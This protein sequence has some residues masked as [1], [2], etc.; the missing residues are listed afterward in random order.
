MVTEHIFLRSHLFL[1]YAHSFPPPEQ[2]ANGRIIVLMCFACSVTKGSQTLKVGQIKDS[3]Y[4]YVCKWRFHLCSPSTNSSYIVY[5][6]TRKENK[7]G[8]CANAFMSCMYGNWGD[9]DITALCQD[10]QALQT[11][12]VAYFYA[13]IVYLLAHAV[14]LFWFFPRQRLL[15]NLVEH[16]LFP[17]KIRILQDWRKRRQRSFV[18][19][20]LYGQALIMVSIATGV[21]F[22]DVWSK[23]PHTYYGGDIVNIFTSIVLFVSTIFNGGWD[24]YRIVHWNRGAEAS[25]KLIKG[26]FKTLHERDEWREGNDRERI[27]LYWYCVYN[28]HDP[29]HPGI[30]RPELMR[31]AL[32]YWNQGRADRNLKLREKVREIRRAWEPELDTIQQ[33][34]YI[35]PDASWSS[36]SLKSRGKVLAYMKA[37][38]A[39]REAF[40]EKHPQGLASFG[41]GLASRSHPACEWFRGWGL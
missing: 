11:A 22:A 8:Q 33:A 6:D 38:F 37:N 10:H 18:S 13:I 25:S 28:R 40:S 9:P 24:L 36:K 20:F 14:C 16:K 3:T 26:V 15:E 23:H 17:A 27:A 21:H 7:A 4:G 12:C 35:D 31:L 30:P 1:V 19:V 29:E 32:V 39:T 2:I 34:W 5:C 41:H